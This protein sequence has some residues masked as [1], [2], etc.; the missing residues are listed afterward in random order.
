[1][2]KQLPHVFT[3]TK[4]PQGYG[5]WVCTE[6]RII[7]KEMRD[8]K[9]TALGLEDTAAREGRRQRGRTATTKNTVGEED[10]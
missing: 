1:M 4:I 9:E 5:L 7:E 10:S 3:M 2:N 6:S 8:R